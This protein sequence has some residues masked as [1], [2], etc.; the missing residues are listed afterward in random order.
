MRILKNIIYLSVYVRRLL[1]VLC[2]FSLFKSV[3]LLFADFPVSNCY[4]DDIFVLCL[5]YPEIPQVGFLLLRLYGELIERVRR[6]SSPVQMD[7][8]V[9]IFF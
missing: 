8:H 7:K 9:T 2:F 4:A 6:S 5:L 3:S 1:W